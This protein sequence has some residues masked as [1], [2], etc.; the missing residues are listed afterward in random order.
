M[1]F[2]ASIASLISAFHHCTN[3]AIKKLW[4]IPLKY[5][6]AC[7]H[8]TKSCY[9]AAICHSLL[10]QI[11]IEDDLRKEQVSTGNCGLIQ[12]ENYRISNALN[13]PN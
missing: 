9:P 5:G 4:E 2:F 11:I 8:D 10:G 7:D 1:P 12:A 13:C 6:F 3:L